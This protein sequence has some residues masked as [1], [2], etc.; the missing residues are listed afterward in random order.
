MA[1][2][3]KK[4][5]RRTRLQQFV[6]EPAA[7]QVIT[8]W[9]MSGKHLTALCRD[10]D[11]PYTQIRDWINAEE[12]RVAKVAK[13]RRD[14]SHAIVDE[15]MDIVD[16]HPPNNA[17]GNTDTG[18][19]SWMKERVQTR[20]WVASMLN[21]SEFG[22]KVDVTHKGDADNPLVLLAQQVQGSALPV[23]K[24]IEQVEDGEEE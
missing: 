24:T 6:A 15:I 23:V 22:D 16:E 3:P 19:V 1:G 18:Y 8:D 5:E 7:I 14:G 2:T 10:M 9:L 17:A 11:L 12:E 4:A 21:P 13:A 20:K